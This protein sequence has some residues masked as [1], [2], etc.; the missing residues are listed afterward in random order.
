[1]KVSSLTG[2]IVTPIKSKA[3][4]MSISP[5]QQQSVEAKLNKR[6][7]P[8][9][10]AKDQLQKMSRCHKYVHHN[11]DVFVDL[12]EM[13]LTPLKSNKLSVML[14][15]EQFDLPV[16]LLRLEENSVGFGNFTNFLKTFLSKQLNIPGDLSFAAYAVFSYGH[17]FNVEVEDSYFELFNYYSDKTICDECES[18]S[19]QQDIGENI[20]FHNLNTLKALQLRDCHF[21]DDSFDDKDYEKEHSDSESYI[22]KDLSEGDSSFH[23][24]EKESSDDPYRFDDIDANDVCVNPFLSSDAMENPFIE[25]SPVH[26]TPVK[27]IHIQKTLCVHCGKNFG[28]TG[29]LKLHLGIMLRH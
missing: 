27:S 29:N 16:Y 10:A 18:V 25:I 21:L 7:T 12:R 3:P 20:Q 5:Q 26:S 4:P 17:K 13:K 15:D 23:S 22:E 14:Q 8:T 9:K 2:A 11:K 6:F 28:K 24:R 19:G 1:M